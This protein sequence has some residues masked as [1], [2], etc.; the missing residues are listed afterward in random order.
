METTL[1][2]GEEPPFRATQIGNRLKLVKAEN[3]LGERVPA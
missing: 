3:N 1:S 2:H